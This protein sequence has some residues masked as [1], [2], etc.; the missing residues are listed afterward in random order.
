MNVSY[1][2]CL[3]EAC[4]SC[5]FAC[6]CVNLMHTHMM[7]TGMTGMDNCS[8]PICCRHLGEAVEWGFKKTTG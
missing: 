5:V 1:I 4:G 6:R 3:F 2:L 7:M 8:C